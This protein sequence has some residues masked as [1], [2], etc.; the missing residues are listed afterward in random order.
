MSATATARTA[1]LTAQEL[2]QVLNGYYNTSTGKG[3]APCPVCDKP[4]KFE[5][6]EK[7][8]KLL[9]ICRRGCEQ[10]RVVEV[11]KDMNLLSRKSGEV[12]RPPI[13]RVLTTKPSLSAVHL[14]QQK[15]HI[16]NSSTPPPLEDL[17]SMYGLTPEDFAA[18]N[19]TTTKWDYYVYSQKAGEWWS[20][21][22][23]GIRPDG[24]HGNKYKT[25][26]RFDKKTEEPVKGTSGKRR[27]C[28]DIGGPGFFPSNTLQGHGELILT[29]G[30]EKALACIK[31]GLR[32]TAWP[33]GEGNFS[34]KMADF[35]LARGNQSFV[36]ALDADDIGAT[37]A[38]KAADLLT[39][40]GAT[41]VRLVQWPATSPKGHDVN[42]TL[43]AGGVSAVQAV[44]DNSVPW[45]PPAPVVKPTGK[46]TTHQVITM[47]EMFA[48]DYKEPVWLV[49]KLLP[50]GMALLVAPDKVGKSWMALKIALAVAQG[51]PIWNRKTTKAGVLYVD[52]EQGARSIKER[53]IK[54]G[55]TKPLEG[56][57]KFIISRDPTMD[58]D[59]RDQIDEELKRDPSIKLVVVDTLERSLS[60]VTGSG[61]AYMLA[62]ARY[63]P[64]QQ[65][66][67][68][69]NISL[70][71][72]HHTSKAKVIQGAQAHDVASGSRG[73]TSTADTPITL[74]RKNG[75]DF[76]LHI[77]GR[78]VEKQDLALTI[79]NGF[80]WI[81]KGTAAAYHV[82]Q[83][84]L[85]IIEILQDQPMTP[86][87]LSDYRGET[88][89]QQKDKTRK[90][91]SLMRKD[92]HLVQSPDG[93]YI[94]P[95]GQAELALED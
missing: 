29:S 19:C 6:T 83:E 21:V 68:D 70:L 81:Y 40:A 38:A 27:M 48:T 8:G 66:A 77:E 55:V 89:K 26:Q 12:Y 35:L 93:K 90:M 51:L 49:E 11:L 61:D 57:F 34:S 80:D 44:I 59:G 13:A 94:V 84:R 47:A 37:G 33:G 91:L 53:L 2:T 4:K 85:E 58:K 3:I 28:T 39:K 22:Y 65:W 72:I 64:L 5:I 16:E 15:N 17:A 10:S 67:N 50:P 73:L 31:A 24:T 71:A 9:F 43:K 78:E 75:D 30:E 92:G 1:S 79:E 45:I 56:T 63:K 62:V 18:N 54:L 86:K 25:F 36:I 82:S 60:M 42:D 52:C 46:P 87:E 14:A 76:T 23:P 20:V 32:A 69:R 7:G 95:T 74:T 41:S 88:T